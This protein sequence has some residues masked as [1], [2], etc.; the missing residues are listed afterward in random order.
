MLCVFPIYVTL[1]VLKVPRVLDESWGGESLNKQDQD[2]RLCYKKKQ[3]LE[4][5]N[6][7]DTVCCPLGEKEPQW[8]EKQ[9]LNQH[10]KS[11]RQ[12]REKQNGK[13]W[14]GEVSSP[15]LFWH[16]RGFSI[17]GFGK[18][19]TLMPSCY[20]RIQMVRWGNRDE[21]WDGRAR[22][23]QRKDGRKISWG[24][25]RE[26]TWPLPSLGVCP[27]QKVGLGKRLALYLDKVTCL[28][29]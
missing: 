12:K 9:L 28:R 10:R 21:Q 27:L 18:E 22:S 8:D 13:H 3:G 19:R 15:F 26:F 20:L 24:R 23:S 5:Q 1:R 11:R 29:V 14:W 7:R 25:P 2:A 16:R 4:D 6:G 17:T